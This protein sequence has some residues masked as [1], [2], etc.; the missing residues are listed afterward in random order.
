M[1]AEQYS[2]WLI[3]QENKRAEGSSVCK[4][5]KLTATRYCTS[6][7]QQHWNWTPQWSHGVV[8]VVYVSQVW[9]RVCWKDECPVCKY[10]C[11]R[12]VQLDLC[13]DQLPQWQV[14][15]GDEKTWSNESSHRMMLHE[16]LRE[17]NKLH[18]C[19]TIVFASDSNVCVR[20]INKCSAEFKYS[21]SLNQTRIPCYQRQREILRRYWLKT[22]WEIRLRCHKQWEC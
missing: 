4:P 8:E 22:V 19:S 10:V 17:S 16:A 20:H 13:R 18:H 3:E 7:E 5:K 21:R 14:V 6:Y 2:C 9:I 11:W 15:I 1:W 12:S